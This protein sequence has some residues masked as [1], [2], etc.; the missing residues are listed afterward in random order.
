MMRMDDSDMGA[1]YVHLSKEDVKSVILQMNN[2]APHSSRKEEVLKVQICLRCREKND[3]ASKFCM[4][5]GTP[6]E[7]NGIVSLER[8]REEKDELAAAVTESD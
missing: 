7:W 5:C 1:V 8:K 4:R 6:L 2:L 3:P